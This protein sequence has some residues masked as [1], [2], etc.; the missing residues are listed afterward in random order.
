M[1]NSRRD[2]TWDEDDEDE[3]EDDEVM[4][5]QLL[6]GSLLVRDGGEGANDESKQGRIR[7]HPSSLQD[8]RAQRFQRE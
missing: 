1:M 8:W 6:G 7:R 4:A 5:D 2:G 3:E